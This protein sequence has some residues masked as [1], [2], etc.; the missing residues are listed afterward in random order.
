MK[1]IYEETMRQ[2]WTEIDLRAL[3][4]NVKEIRS[5]LKPETKMIGVVKADAYGHGCIE[6]ARV[7]SRNNIDYFAVST[8]SEAIELREGGCNEDIIILGVT[9]PECAGLIVKQNLTP[10]IFS[11]DAAK[12]YSDE[13]EKRGKVTKCLVKLDTGMGR[14]GIRVGDEAESERAVEDVK[15]ISELPGLEVLGMMTHLATSDEADRSYTDE[16]LDCFDR[17]LERLAEQ[18]IK[19]KLNTAANSAAV[20]QHPR[21]EYDAVRPGL[22]L[23]GYY[24]SKE[25][26][27]ETIDLQPVMSIRASIVNLKTVPAGTS[28]SYGRKF[29]TKR[30]SRIAT[31]GLGYADGFSRVLSGK[32]EAI[33]HGVRVPIVGSI[34]M[35]QCMIDVTDVPEVK[36]GDIVTIMGKDGAEEIS[37]EEIAE[38]LGTINYEV[39]CCFALRLPKVFLR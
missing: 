23:Y 22:I 19:F 30:E 1:V 33:V 29:T 15:R 17:V 9:P 37:A 21:S 28:V 8:I 7:L 27:R 10:V 34:C 12:R 35:D 31:I 36:A 39:A 3:D 4:H 18:G 20:I 13:S 6:C 38:K 25:I 14:I 5:K 24:P 32:A 16:Q 2:A 26:S 11:Y